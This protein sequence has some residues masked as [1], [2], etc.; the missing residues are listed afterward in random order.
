MVVDVS[1][2]GMGWLAVLALAFLNLPSAQISS[3]GLAALTATIVGVIIFC[4]FGIVKQAEELASRLGDPYGTLVL[5]LS[6]VFIEVTLIV[7]VLNGPGN[8][9]A[10]ARD[11]VFAVSMIILN[12]VVGIC[13]VVGGWGGKVMTYNPQG[14]SIYQSLLIVFLSLGLVLPAFIGDQGAYSPRVSVAVALVTLGAYGGFLY[15][16]M[17]SGAGYFRE[18]VSS[19][20]SHEDLAPPQRTKS[21]R[22]S[23]RNVAFLVLAAIPLVLLSHYLAG[24]LDEGIGRL[25]AP[26]AFS[27]VLIAAIVF[28]PES[29]TSVR[30]AMN[31]RTQRVINLCH[32]ALVSTVCL[33]IP[34]VLLGGLMAKR[35]VILGLPSVELVLLAATLLLTLL[36]FT[37]RRPTAMHGLSHLVLFG[38]YLLVL[39]A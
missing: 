36:T 17:T 5:T 35:T 19:G 14:A 31:G 26:P 24:F 3:W 11:S 4:A 25:G 29:I 20:A 7:S 22:S 16:Q 2:V 32:G 37:T 38:G 10:I 33:T 39:V 30:A 9:P 8:H 6:I 18:P 28:L 34:A 1:R 27:G 15:F 21:V 12:L 13:L 23:F